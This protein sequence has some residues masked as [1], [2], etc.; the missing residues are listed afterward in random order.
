[1]E[2]HGKNLIGRTQSA[3][4]TT[5]FSGITIELR[6]KNERGIWRLATHAR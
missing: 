6:N 2:S 3:K 5:T 4:G 1:M